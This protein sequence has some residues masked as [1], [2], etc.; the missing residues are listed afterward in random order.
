VQHDSALLKD[1]RYVERQTIGQKAVIDTFHHET[2]ERFYRDWYRPELMAVIAVGDF[3]PAQIRALIQQHF[4]SIPPTQNGRERPIFPVPNH[5]ETLFSIASD[6]EF[7][8]SLVDIIYKE[9]VNP[10][11]TV[12]DYRQAL[13]E[14]LYILTLGQRLDELSK[15]PEAPFISATFFS[16]SNLW[17]MHSKSVKWLQAQAKPNQLELGLEGLL[18]EVERAARHGFTPSE[19]ERQKTEVLR[20]FEQLFRERD[21][22][23][24]AQLV[25][26]YERHYLFDETIPGI[27]FEFE[28]ATQLLPGIEV[29]EIDQ[30]A[31]AQTT[32]RNRVIAISSPEGPEV[33]IPQEADLRAVIERVR[34][35]DIQPYVDVVVDR[36]LIERLPDPGDI[37]DEAEIPALEVTEWTLA[38]GVR[39]VLKP[40]DF[41]DDQILF[42]AYSPGGHS[43]VADEDYVAAWTA[44]NV[45]E[46]MGLGSFGLIELE[47]K[48]SGQVVAVSPWIAELQEGLSGSASPEDVETMFQLIHLFFTATRQD[49]SAFLT[50]KNRERD[51]VT[52]R[53]LDPLQSFFDAFQVLFSQHHPRARPWSTEVVEEMD[54]EKSLRIYRERFANAGD[55]TFILVGNLDLEQI[56]PLVQTYLGSLPSTGRQETWKDVGL[57][58][59]RGVVEETIHQGLSPLSLTGLIFSGDFEWTPQNRFE[60]D[61]LERMLGLMIFNTLRQ[62]LGAIYGFRAWDSASRDPQPGY[63]ITIG[64]PSAPENVAPLKAAFF[65]LIDELHV[66]GPAEEDLNT[67][68][69]VM[70]L[71]RQEAAEDNGFWLNALQSSYRYEEDPLDILAYDERVDGLTTETVRAA[72]QRYLNV[73]NYVQLIL[74]PEN[75]I[76]AVLEEHTAVLPQAFALDQNYPNPFNSS[77]AIRFALPKSEE[78]ELA[79]YNLTGQ[80]VVTLVQGRRDAGAYTILWDGR[81]DSGHALASGMYLYRLEAGDEVQTRKLV[82]LQ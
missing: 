58:P 73:Q 78:V 75:F 71:E 46:N 74:H 53:D 11:Q 63:S 5:D 31:R 38:N 79:V 36:P 45:I 22:I 35:K 12:G 55:F 30:L 65:E 59:L 33:L 72:A 32:E 37:V 68:R 18:T 69:E 3:D 42:T 29:E 62:E 17:D 24:S 47:R 13:V 80:Q 66:S 34:G 64:Y 41:Q 67:V 25:E 19:L 15:Q 56:R 76:S 48:L 20:F 61:A 23:P 7:P 16:Q 39:V 4:A 43:L 44:A 70:R 82:L 40:T 60:L 57:R 26:E 28:M 6:P 50:Y 10:S 77:T 21:Q 1:S 14:Q 27:E 8:V 9:E 49:E 81:D 51:A 52:N 54:M 2:L